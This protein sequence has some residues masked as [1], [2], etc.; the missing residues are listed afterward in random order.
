MTGE[1][2]SYPEGIRINS[3][4]ECT[5]G[6]VLAG[7]NSLIGAV[8]KVKEELGIKLNPAKGRRISQIC[9]EE[10]QDLYDVWIFY[11][12]IDISDIILQET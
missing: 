6:S 2:I 9:R 4:W 8:R 10:T 5:G 7:E 12:N 1:S 11:K 3:I